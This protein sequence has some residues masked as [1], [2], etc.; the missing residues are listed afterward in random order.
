[1]EN[2]KYSIVSIESDVIEYM[3]D[4]VDK[5]KEEKILARKRCITLVCIPLVFII[6]FGLLAASVVHDVQA[7]GEHVPGGD[8]EEPSDLSLLCPAGMSWSGESSKCEARP[9]Y[10][11]CPS[12][13][14]Q[15]SCARQDTARA[16]RCC[17]L[18]GILPSSYKL[19]C[20]QGWV[21]VEWRHVCVRV[22]EQH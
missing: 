17:H 2:N 7:R 13:T 22:E 14:Q 8:G 9:G 1:M 5:D 6:S 12:C 19:L 20:R 21:W 3:F 15:Y 16:E 4:C 11:C 10:T 18:L